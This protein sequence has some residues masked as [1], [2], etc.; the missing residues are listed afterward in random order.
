[1]FGQTTITF[2]SNFQ[3]PRV[4]STDR[5]WPKPHIGSSNSF[6]MSSR[7]WTANQVPTRKTRRMLRK[8]LFF[9]ICFG[10]KLPLPFRNILNNFWQVC[11]CQENH[12]SRHSHEN[13]DPDGNR[14]FID[15]FLWYF[16]RGSLKL[17][18]KTWTTYLGILSSLVLSIFNCRGSRVPIGAGPNRPWGPQQLRYY[19]PSMRNLYSTSRAGGQ[20]STRF[21]SQRLIECWKYHHYHDSSCFNLPQSL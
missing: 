11:V 12:I 14:H 17:Q 2:S 9:Y 1:M 20:P 16:V 3:F 8:S 10:L 5:C 13:L 7:R 15:S 21:S 18:T 19:S 6:S 4:Q